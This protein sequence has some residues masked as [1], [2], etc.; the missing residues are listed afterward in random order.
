MIAECDAITPPCWKSSAATFATFGC[1]AGL[2][3]KR[4]DL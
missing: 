1:N 2:Q 3:A 4:L